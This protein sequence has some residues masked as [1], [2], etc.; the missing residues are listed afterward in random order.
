MNRVIRSVPRPTIASP[1]LTRRAALGVALAAVVP[2]LAG[3]TVPFTSTSRGRGVFVVGGDGQDL[4]RVADGSPWLAWSP[5]S[6]TLGLRYPDGAIV[7]AGANGGGTRPYAGEPFTGPGWSP[8]GT[9]LAVVNPEQDVIRVEAA[10]GSVISQAPL[11]ETRPP[12]WMVATVAD[13][14]PV[15]SPTGERIAFLAWDGNGDAL[16]TIN[17]D[18]TDRRKRSVVPLSRNTADRYPWLNQR[19]AAG[20]V[21]NPA[22]SPDGQ[23]LSYAVFPEVRGA[24]GGIYVVP[25]SGGDRTEVTGRPPVSGP[26]W[27]PTGQEIAYTARQDTSISLF[28]ASAD[29]LRQRTLTGL[30][31]VNARYPA[32]SPDGLWIAFAGGRDLFV[33]DPGGNSRHLA[34]TGLVTFDPMWSP[35]GTKIAFLGVPPQPGR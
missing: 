13:N 7:V 28:V 31:G 33:T 5:D 12:L 26:A 10:D 6:Q 35:D 25:A 22:W 15:W 4:R 14:I 20:D 3:C 1:R 21:G 16:Y 9:R 19:V 32:W 23:F 30:L 29:G 11:R 18:G 27:S 24:T 8:D 2:A 17:P 34:S